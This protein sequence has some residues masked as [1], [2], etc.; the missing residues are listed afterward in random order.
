M[1]KVYVC[2]YLYS[3]SLLSDIYMFY[4]R[5]VFRHFASF[6]DIQRVVFRIL[7]ASKIFRE[8]YLGILLASKIFREWY[9]DIL[10]AS[11]VFRDWYIGILLPPQMFIF[12]HPLKQLAE[13]QSVF[14]ECLFCL[15]Y[16]LACFLTLIPNSLSCLH[17]LELS[18]Y[19]FYS[20]C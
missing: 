5:V 7:L 1:Q 18:F 16:P 14:L 6:Q 10:L 15:H 17:R 19:V 9:S 20:I 12:I 13:I 2:S 11:K 8:R 3:S 4:R